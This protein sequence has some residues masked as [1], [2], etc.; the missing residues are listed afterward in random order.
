MDK[1]IA[2]DSL[3]MSQKKN[4]EDEF[5]PSSGGVNEVQSEQVHHGPRTMDGEE[6]VGDT[7]SFKMR[8]E[9]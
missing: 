1:F 7:F 3:C 5:T 9:Q 4:F 6:F 8:P 2:K